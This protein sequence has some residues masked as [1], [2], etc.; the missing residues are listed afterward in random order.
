MT[1][2]EIPAEKVNKA[3]QQACAIVNKRT[4]LKGFRRGK[5]PQQILEK[6]MTVET[7]K[8]EAFKLLAPEIKELIGEKTLLS[9]TFELGEPLILEVE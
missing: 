2:L 6:I 9:Y 8:Y 1:N 3:Y 5:I 4:N 7:L